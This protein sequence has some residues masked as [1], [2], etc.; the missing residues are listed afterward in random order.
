M[1]QFAGDVTFKEQPSEL[2]F[3]SG[4]GWSNARTWIGAPH[5]LDN[6]LDTGLPP[7]FTALSIRKGVVQTVVE[8]EYGVEDGRNNSP[9]ADPISRIWTLDGTDVE[10]SV[11]ALPWVQAYLTTRP[12]SE[13]RTINQFMSDALRDGTPEQLDGTALKKLY[14]L[15]S[16]KQ[17]TFRHTEHVLRKVQVVT[18]ESELKAVHT[19]VNRVFNYHQLVQAEDTL[20]VAE[21]IDA[22]SLQDYLWLKGSPKVDQIGRGQFQINQEY[23]SGWI[24]EPFIFQ[25]A[26]TSENVFKE[27]DD[28]TGR[29]S[30]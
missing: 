2:R 14:V 25:T 1:S 23:T 11:W 28:K 16:T 29:A 21:L 9:I 6:F 10:L 12:A 27:P 3:R 4:S 26:G 22:A 8:A 24:F 5:E 17:E 20:P 15:L 7:L 19:D 30:F 18:R 13:M